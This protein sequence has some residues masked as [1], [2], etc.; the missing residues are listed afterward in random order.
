LVREP[1]FLADKSPGDL[2]GLAHSVSILEAALGVAAI[3]S[4]LKVDLDAC[5]ELNA[6]ELI[7]QKGEGRTVSLVG[8]F[9]FAPRVREKAHRLWVIEKNPEESDYPESAAETLIPQADVVGITGTALTNHTLEHLLELCNPRAYVVLLGDSVPL[10]PLFFDYGVDA[11]CG[12][13]VVDTDIALRCV[14][15]GATFRQIKGTRRLTLE[16]R[17][18]IQPGWRGRRCTVR[19]A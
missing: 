18:G 10:S 1:G 13:A 19:E 2:A 7:L 5:V 8:R 16:K 12:T 17:P 6:G 11:V 4:L 15:Q 9:P 3:N 14:S